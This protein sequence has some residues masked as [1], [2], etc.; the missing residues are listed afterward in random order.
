MDVLIPILNGRGLRVVAY[1]LAAMLSFAAARQSSRGASRREWP[2]VGF[3]LMAGAALVLL[4]LSREVDLAA[5]GADIGRNLFRTEGWYPDRRPFQEAAVLGILAC[6]GVVSLCGSFLLLSGRRKQILP[7]FVALVCLA[8]FLAVRAISLHD[9]DAVLY[10]HSISQ[11]RVNAL[12]ELAVTLLIALA[13]LLATSIRR[14]RMR[15]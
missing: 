13:A 3:W 4:A 10:R 11:V 12:A 9:I 7:G 15:S 14:P 2:L 6:A 1:L 5:R 8:T